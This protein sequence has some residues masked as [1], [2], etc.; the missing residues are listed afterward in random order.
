M[1]EP[2][3]FFFD[4]EEDI[5]KPI[6]TLLETATGKKSYFLEPSRNHAAVRWDW[7][8][9]QGAAGIKLDNPGHFPQRQLDSTE[10]RCD[11]ACRGKTHGDAWKMLQQLLS[12]SRRVKY[13][14]GRMETWR[15]EESSDQ[16]A[17]QKTVITVTMV[18]TMPLLEQ[19]LD[20][21]TKVAPATITNVQ[22]DTTSS[23]YGVDD[24]KL[25]VPTG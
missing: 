20:A 4:P 24:G 10:F 25:I 1:P 16:A 12:A 8:P 17:T 21:Q 13:A 15:V 11:I 3:Q 7:T 6:A 14:S 5:F 19:P 9:T 2:A 22:F 23:P 18:W